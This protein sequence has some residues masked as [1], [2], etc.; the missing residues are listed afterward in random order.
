MGERTR[1]KNV[2]FAI[3]GSWYLPPWHI[4]D[5]DEVKQF[6]IGA[7]RVL[8]IQ[9]LAM[10]ECTFHGEGVKG[11][12]SINITGPCNVLTTT[13]KGNHPHRILRQAIV[14]QFAVHCVALTPCLGS[15]EGSS[16]QGWFDHLESR[17]L[18]FKHLVTNRGGVFYPE[19]GRSTLSG[20]LLFRDGF[21][22]KRFLWLPCV[23]CRHGYAF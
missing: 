19:R 5:T 9:H 8:F 12:T 16:I 7:C 21:Y 3:P 13:W 22:L 4:L 15:K 10:D 6:A 17:G 1:N 18:L 20:S 23:I 11:D 14:L 2:V